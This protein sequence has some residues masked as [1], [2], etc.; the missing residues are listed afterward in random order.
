MPN[1]RTQKTILVGVCTRAELFVTSKLMT[2]ELAP[3]GFEAA[4]RASLE[5]LGLERLDL[6]LLQW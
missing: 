6:L 2:Y 1:I 4:V 3:C 5:Q